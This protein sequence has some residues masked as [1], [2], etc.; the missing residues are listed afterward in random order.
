MTAVSGAYEMGRTPAL[1]GVPRTIL[2]LSLAGVLFLVGGAACFG[3]D[4]VRDGRPAATIV[5]A[6]DAPG[7]V[8]FA[9]TE[10]QAYVEKATGATLP[11][12]ETGPPDGGPRVFVGESEATRQLGLS[13]EGLRPDGFSIIARDNWLALFG[14]E[15]EPV[16]ANAHPFRPGQ[17]YHPPSGISRYGETGALYA[18]YQFLYDHCGIRWYMPGELGEVVP[19]QATIEV[20]DLELDR[21]PDFEYRFLYHADLVKDDDATYWYRRIGYGAPTPVWINHSFFWFNK[22]RETNP[23]Y[24]ALL[25]DGSRDF[26]VT[27]DPPGNFCLSEP[28]FLQQVVADIRAYFDENPGQRMFPVMPNDSWTR[29]CECDKCQAQVNPDSRT[30]KYSDYLWNFVNEVAR[31]IHESHPDKLIGCCAYAHYLDPPATIEKLSPNVAVMIA[32]GPRAGRMTDEYRDFVEAWSR[33]ADTLYRWEY[34]LYGLNDRTVQGLPMLFSANIA[35]DLRLLKGKSGGELIEAE[36]WRA[37]T[38]DTYKMHYPGMTHLN[39]YL[40]GKLLWDAEADVDALLEDYYSRFY[41]PAREP[42]R[43]FWTLAERLWTERT[44]EGAPQLFGVYTEARIDELLSHLNQA[45]VSCAPESPERRRVELLLSELS[46]VKDRV[47]NVRV[48]TRVSVG[49]PHVPVPPVIDGVLD[50]EAWRQAARIDF[51]GM[52]GEPAEHGTDGFLAWDEQH[53][54]LAFVNAEPNPAGIRALATERDGRTRPYIWDDD[55][56]EIIINVHPVQDKQYYQFIVN[57][58]GTLWD[59]FWGSDEFGPDHYMWD[60]GFEAATRVGEN[61]W[62]AEIRIPLQDLGVTEPEGKRFSANFYRNRALEGQAM[63]YSYWSPTLVFNHHRPERFGFI[64]LEGT[65]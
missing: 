29:I 19:R 50:D 12:A 30:G 3:M 9:A 42:M 34:Y 49:V 40:T 11:I 27:S 18:V 7:M 61:E 28:G 57:A 26:N 53:L 31:Q 43:A 44:A 4:L 1:R 46:P 23:E 2:C 38:D 6:P 15:S 35:E 56:V 60:S 25:P 20:G 62:V 13:A 37:R 21:A 8:R 65:Q 24:Y 10:L 52:T 51:V 55:A 48:S 32:A 59:G 33:K 36:S 17:S 54:Y 63:Q 47:R 14:R 39:L 64:T 45:A 16:Y 5:V 41:G 22:Y 58:R